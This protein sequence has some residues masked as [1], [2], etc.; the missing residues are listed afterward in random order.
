MHFAC[1]FIYSSVIV[2][3][4]IWWELWNIY[5]WIIE[6]IYL[7]NGS[8]CVH[9]YVIYIRITARSRNFYIQQANQCISNIINQNV[10]AIINRRLYT[11]HNRHSIRTTQEISYYARLLLLR[12]Y[13]NKLIYAY[14]KKKKLFLYNSPSFTRT[15]T[16]RSRLIFTA[17][18]RL[19][20]RSIHSPRHFTRK[21][22]SL[23]T[24]ARFLAYA[25]NKGL[26][27]RGHHGK[28]VTTRGVCEDHI[29]LPFIPYP[30]IPRW[31]LAPEAQDTRAPVD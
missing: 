19:I 29:F 30:S 28:R 2:T 23:S 12:S 25:N 5:R 27:T 4:R 26:F 18:M 16:L 15:H 6:G 7:S 1:V 24:F 31:W 10:E 20:S 17:I 11:W 9:T 22:F 14:K 21:A 13:T 8:N 3:L